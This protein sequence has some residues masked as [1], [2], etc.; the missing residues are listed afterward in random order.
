MG[1]RGKYNTEDLKG[2]RFGKWKVIQRASSDAAGIHW[3]CE[4]DCGNQREVIASSLFRKESKSCGCSRYDHKAAPQRGQERQRVSNFKKK[5]DI[6]LAER[7]RMEAAQG[8]KCAL[9]HKPSG[10][11]DVDHDHKNGRIRGLLCHRC[12]VGIGGLDNLGVELNGVL[13][14]LGWK[15]KQ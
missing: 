8:R 2:Q 6:D 10:R 7:E 1:K 11:L 15:P 12:N 13:D 9:C 5:Y 3:L 4:C 14:Y